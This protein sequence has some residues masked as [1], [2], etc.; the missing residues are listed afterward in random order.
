MAGGGDTLLRGATCSSSLQVLALDGTAGG[1]GGGG[2]GGGH[3]VAGWQAAGAMRHPRCGL[4]LAS[5]ARRD[6]LYLV[7]GYSGGTEYQDT[8]ETFD[9]SSGRGALL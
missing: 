9:P 3:A 4:A 2:G 7:G 1:G 6:T 5:D 8:V